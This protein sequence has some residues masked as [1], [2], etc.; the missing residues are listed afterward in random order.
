MHSQSLAR[1]TPGNFR[2]DITQNFNGS[3]PSAGGTA[4]IGTDSTLQLNG[5][6]VAGDST[7]LEPT[8]KFAA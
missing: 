1:K 5:A 8:I 2:L 4:T 6:G 7:V 3:I